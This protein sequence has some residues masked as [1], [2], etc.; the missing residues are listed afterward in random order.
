MPLNPWR[1]DLLECFLL[2]SEESI[3]LGAALLPCGE[4][5][6]GFFSEATALVPLDFDLIR[7]RVSFLDFG[8]FG[9]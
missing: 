5:S 8:V 1:N 6:K 2:T 7:D 3:G 4:P 9:M